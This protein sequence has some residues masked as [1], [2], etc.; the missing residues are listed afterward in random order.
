MKL[1]AFILIAVSM[2]VGVIGALTA[3]VP[4]LSLPDERL[5]NLTL[6][7]AAGNTSAD[8]RAPKPVAA[9]GAA[10][11]PEVLAELRS[12]GVE[13][14]R[15]KEFA[16]NRW[17]EWWLFA[18]GCAGLGV[19]AFMVR[20]VS[21][22]GAAASRAETA[23]GGTA[24]LSPAQTIDALRAEIDVLRGKLAVTSSEADRLSLMLQELGRMQQTH[25]AAFIGARA[26]LTSRLGLGGYA[27]VMDSFAAAERSI[28]RA[29]SAAADEVEAE[30]RASID[31]AADLLVQTRERV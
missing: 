27:R 1:A 19:G 17:P 18:L 24:R 13:R 2:C 29:W 22:R 4:P 14:I 12:A 5:V 20:M 11:T 6:N 21:K 31:H 3:Y 7:A 30:A 15:V 8:L 28:N 25:I 16:F 10:V 9:K 23:T 26:E